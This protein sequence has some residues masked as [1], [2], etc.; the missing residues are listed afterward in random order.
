MAKNISWPGILRPWYIFDLIHLQICQVVL[1]VNVK[2]VD[3]S[4][5][6]VY[7][8]DNSESDI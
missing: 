7:V 6:N 3:T 1:E 8:H 4:T 2:R 5:L